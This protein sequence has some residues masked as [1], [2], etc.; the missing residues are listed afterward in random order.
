MNIQPTVMVEAKPWWKSKVVILNV[1]AGLAMLIPE[2]SATVEL[3]AGVKSWMAG[4]L[5]VVNVLLRFVSNQP[6]T[7]ST[8]AKAIEVRAA[9]PGMPT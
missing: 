9:T 2:L 5:V 1:L 8:A 4:L 6:V 3:P 7:A